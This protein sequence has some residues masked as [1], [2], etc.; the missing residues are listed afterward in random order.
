M[1]IY[2]SVRWVLSVVRLHPLLFLI[3]LS[4]R[5]WR[6]VRITSSFPSYAINSSVLSI[7]KK[8]AILA[9]SEDMQD[10][11]D[12]AVQYYEETGTRANIQDL[13]NMLYYQ[14]A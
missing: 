14:V 3:A 12:K 5:F 9:E 6:E 13:L 10:I 1:S 8:M 7:Y 2:D 11:R 4:I